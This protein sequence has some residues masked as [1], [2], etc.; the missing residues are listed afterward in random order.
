MLL[1]ALFGMR[2]RPALTA[3]LLL[4]ACRGPGTLG[5]SD[6]LAQRAPR[7][8]ARVG[9]EDRRQYLRRARIFDE[10][11]VRKRD[12]L[13]GPHDAQRFHF[14]QRVS[15]DF[16]EPR[17]GD[18]PPLGT[19]PKFYCTLSGRDRARVKVKYGR[20]NPELYG[21]LLG[22]RLLWLLGVASDADYAVRV[23]CRGC[24]V[25][26]WGAYL[27]FPMR[28]R[29]PRLTR[30]VDD[31]LIQ[32]LYPG[33]DIETHP[34]QGWSF[35]ELGLLDEAVG[36]ATRADVDALRLLSAFIAHGDDKPENQ[37]LVCPFADVDAAGHCTRPR[38]LIA[39]LGSTFG[40]G[41]NRL[42]LIDEASRPSFAA[43]SSSPVWEDRARCRANLAARSSHSNPLI[44][45]AGRQRLAARLGALSRTQIRNLFVY[46]RIERLGET[47]RDRDRRIRPVSVDDW[48]D[49]FERRRAEI[50]S[51]RCP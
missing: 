50:T 46:A 3:A 28:D 25:D 17:A 10:V 1:R 4:A 49:V 35:D 5:V 18:L 24:P 34:D 29:S 31:A 39:D 13:S 8:L 51:A 14:D 26:P 6:V 32:R 41:A 12:V 23:R 15:C 11:D 27:R 20:T 7:Q 47:T 19:T 45:E 48:S 21:E 30:D 16:I 40:R 2:L 42:S 33:L 22:S 44:S 38:L 43:W 36:G 9:P 37:R